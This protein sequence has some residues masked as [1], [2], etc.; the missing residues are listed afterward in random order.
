MQLLR[1]LT[2]FSLLWL[3]LA[4]DDFAQHIHFNPEGPNTVGYIYVGD[5]EKAIDESTWIYIKKALEH[6]QQSKPIFI[7]LELNTPGGEVFVAQKISDALR[8]SDTQ[9]NVPVVTFINNW[10]I[11]A[12]AMLAYSTRYITAVHDAS[13]GAAAPILFDETGKMTEAS[14]KINSAIRT[15]FENRARFFDRNPLIAEA[16][17]DK[18]LIVVQRDGKIIKLDTENQIRYNEPNA[19]QII[20]PKGKLLTLDGEQLLHYGIANL[21]VPSMK[22]DPITNK[23]LSEGKWPASKIALFHTPFFSSIPNATIEAYQM[24]WKTHLFALLASPAVTSIL[25]MGLMIGAYME[26]SNPGLSLPGS[27]AAICLFLLIIAN[28]SLDIA[29][30]LEAILLLTGIALLIIEIFVL[31]SFGLLGFFGILLFVVGLFGMI[32]PNIRSISFD[33]DTQTLNAAGEYFFIRLAWLSGAFIISLI[34][35]AILSRYFV[36]RF[37]GFKRFVLEG[38]EQE[39]FTAGDLP[40]SFPEK[41]TEGEAFTTLRPAGKIIVKGQIYDAITR[42][43]FIEQGASII[44]VGLEGNSLI[45]E[46]K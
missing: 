27:I 45:V 42:G 16:M 34:V 17:V 41:G 29:N 36:P 22:L 19:D 43:N 23:E 33:T 24:D 8:V 28:L 20:S 46:H 21:L 2:L 1:F 14:E 35:I 38:N 37:S 11:S 4:G 25:F 31:P 12:G 3:H 13:M 7:L 30:W 5:H 26:F 18:D 15:D 6:Y 10:A 9:E 39:G 40:Q 44:I 32:L